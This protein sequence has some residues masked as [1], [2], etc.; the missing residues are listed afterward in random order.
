MSDSASLKA[1]QVA[2]DK[3]KSAY[4]LYE[5]VI[6]YAESRSGGT[7]TT[8][9]REGINLAVCAFLDGVVKVQ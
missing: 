4:L 5:K 6:E 2:T 7:L 8:E 3:T 1:K 9:Q